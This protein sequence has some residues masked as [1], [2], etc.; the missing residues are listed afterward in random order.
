MS[1]FDDQRI[2]DGIGGRAFVGLCRG[3][4][5]HE[6][7]YRIY[8]S[9]AS[10]T[11]GSRTTSTCS[12]ATRTSPNAPCTHGERERRID[13]QQRQDR[14]GKTDATHAWSPVEVLVRCLKAGDWFKREQLFL[15]GRHGRGAGVL[16]VPTGAGNARAD[17][18]RATN[19]TI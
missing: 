16:A 15:R 10:S 8:G 1:A 6:V 3:S 17:K 12:C 7:S 2:L 18:L 19:G 4:G 5:S 13:C 14:D 11:S 9:A